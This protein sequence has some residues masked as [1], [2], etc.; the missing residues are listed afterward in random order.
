MLLKRHALANAA[1]ALRAA[2]MSDGSGSSY[3]MQA[4]R[5][6]RTQPGSVMA[7]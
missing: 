1:D 2:R 3:S 4:G 5:R 7:A 6:H